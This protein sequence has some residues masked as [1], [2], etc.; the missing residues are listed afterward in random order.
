[1]G[2]INNFFLTSGGSNLKPNWIIA[3]HHKEKP[4]L[5]SQR[6]PALQ[7]QAVLDHDIVA[8]CW[9]L[10]AEAAPRDTVSWHAEATWER[11]KHPFNWSMETWFLIISKWQ[12]RLSD[13]IG[14]DIWNLGLNGSILKLIFLLW[15]IFRLPFSPSSPLIHPKILRILDLIHLSVS[16]LFFKILTQEA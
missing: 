9:P 14:L 10:A 2:A 8:A 16:S 11:T 6:R 3:L 13:F 15:T 4:A 5:E 1:M 7:G 12:V